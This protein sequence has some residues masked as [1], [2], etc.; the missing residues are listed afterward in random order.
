MIKQY[1]RITSV[2]T[3][4]G[5]EQ[6]VSEILGA[7][8]TRTP[9]GTLLVVDAYGNILEDLVRPHSHTAGMYSLE[10]GDKIRTV[11][12]KIAVE[13]AE[14]APVKAA[15]EAPVKAAK[16]PFWIASSP[17]LQTHATEQAALLAASR[18]AKDNPGTRFLVFGTQG[19]H[20]RGSHHRPGLIATLRGVQ[21]IAGDHM[22]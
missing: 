7:Y 9:S 6:R 21:P 5:F 18:A 2:K 12:A 16:G 20:L 8:L 13:E 17:S 22:L 11:W 15:K 1:R 19:S 4:P 3:Q 10:L 14:E